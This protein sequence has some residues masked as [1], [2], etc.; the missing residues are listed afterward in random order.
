[1]YVIEVRN[2]DKD[3]I[4]YIAVSEKAVAKED[5]T[6]YGTLTEKGKVKFGLKGKVKFGLARTDRA[7][8][9]GLEEFDVD[10][11][12]FTA[13]DCHGLKWKYVSAYHRWDVMEEETV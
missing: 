5:I 10:T 11:K 9:V 6:E 8:I 12:T 1:M 13:T 3:G 2:I 7:E 4:R